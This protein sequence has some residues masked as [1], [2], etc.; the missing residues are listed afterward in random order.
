MAPRLVRIKLASPCSSVLRNR[1]SPVRQS[2][3]RATVLAAYGNAT[4][5][6]SSGTARDSGRRNPNPGT[7]AFQ[8]FTAAHAATQQKPIDGKY[9]YRSA[10]TLAGI[11]FGFSTGPRGRKSKISAKERRCARRHKK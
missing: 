9:R 11:H 2:R 7:S 4:A 1:A 5:I 8:N 10:K 3:L 6:S